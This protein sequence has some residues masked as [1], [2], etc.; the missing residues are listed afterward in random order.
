MG[1]NVERLQ[2]LVIVV[3]T[4]MTAAAV[5]ISGVISWVGLLIPHIARMVI[6]PR[7]RQLLP[8]SFLIGGAF[9]LIVD[10][11]SRSIVSL[12][13]PLGITTSLI[14]APFFI[15]ILLKNINRKKQ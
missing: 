5:S 6:G 1:I 4:L 3:A 15:F 11:F 7:N 8:A 9:L 12:E 2:F 14:G 13:I 10:N